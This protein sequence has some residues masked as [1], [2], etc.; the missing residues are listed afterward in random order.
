VIWPNP[1]AMGDLTSSIHLAQ[2]SA[3]WPH[4]FLDRND[5]MHLAYESRSVEH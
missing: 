4:Q 5:G 3:S 2:T 1:K